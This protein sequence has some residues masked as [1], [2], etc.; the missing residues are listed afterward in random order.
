MKHSSRKLNPYIT[1][2]EI[3]SDIKTNL[4]EKMEILVS[5][6]LRLS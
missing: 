6:D 2:K 3:P 1:G 4:A 5:S